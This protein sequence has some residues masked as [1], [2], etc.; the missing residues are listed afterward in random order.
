MSQQMSHLPSFVD[1]HGLHSYRQEIERLPLTKLKSLVALKIP[2]LRLSSRTKSSYID[3]LIALAPHSVIKSLYEEAIRFRGH[4]LYDEPCSSVPCKRQRDD[5]SSTNTERRQRQ[6][7]GSEGPGLN[8]GSIETS[9]MELPSDDQVKQCYRDFYDLTQPSKLIGKVCAVCAREVNEEHNVQTRSIDDIPNRHRLQPIYRHDAHELYNGLLFEPAGLK[10][11]GSHIIVTICGQCFRELEKP[12]PHPPL[13]SL[14]NNLWIGPIPWELSSLTQPEQLL[15]ALLY[16]RVFVYKLYNKTWYNTDQSTLQRGMRGTVCTYEMNMD[17]I[18]SMLQ[19]DLMPRPMEI[20]S[21]II[22]ITFI[23]R[24][25]LSLSRL[26]TLFRVRQRAVTDALMWLK[27]NNPKY[28][29]GVVIDQERLARL[30]EDAVPVEIVSTVRYSNDE[31]LIEQ[32]SSPYVS[33]GENEAVES[34]EEFPKCLYF[35]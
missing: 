7:I 29:G 35:N 10:M 30:P 33:Y 20:L 32:E 11:D 6:C 15:I 4:M 13:H 18:S 19:G 22:V 23:G 12:S 5:A 1:M 3:T 2:T 14:A 21:S 16:P 31:G 24:G 28:Y 26:H 17:S 25:K 9:F 27:A 8:T 34:G